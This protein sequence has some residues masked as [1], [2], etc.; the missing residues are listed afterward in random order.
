MKKIGLTY[1]D[2]NFENYPVWIKGEDTDIEVIIL[3]YKENNIDDAQQ[4]DAFVFSG[5]VDVHPTMYGNARLNFPHNEK[6]EFN[7]LRD[8]FEKKVFDIAQKKQVPVL[9]ICRGMQL[10]NCLLGGDLI[11]DLEEMSKADHKS[12]NKVDGVHIVNLK[13]DSELYKMANI[14]QGNINSAHHQS[15]GK[16]AQQLEVVAI[17]EDD[18][19]E[20][21]EYKNKKN[22]PWM[23]CVQWHP[24]RLT[25]KDIIPFS[26]NI[27]ESFLASI[28]K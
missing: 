2:T 7:I 9:G 25:T 24:E 18:V 22:Q 28:K 6:G 4:C 12:H 26:R 5:G 23:L 1:T 3:S 11:Q 19:P 8:E 15:V 17:S 10:I 21:V 14:S 20:A 13:N 16:I 27:R